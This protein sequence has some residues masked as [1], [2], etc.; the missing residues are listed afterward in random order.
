L[1]INIAALSIFLQQN[2]N[3]M[4][5]S[6]DLSIKTD[7][8]GFN[9]E[10]FEIVSRKLLSKPNFPQVT[11]KHGFLIFNAYAIKALDEC[12]H[13]KI[14][15]NI[16]KK[17]MIAKPC[18]EYTRDSVQWSKVDKLGNMVPKKIIGKPFTGRLFYDMY[19]DFKGTYKI[20]GKQI[21]D[22]DEKMLEFS[23]I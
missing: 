11:L 23:L 2:V 5:K 8:S 7:R 22:R 3:I 13:I 17:S 20:K 6:N 1:I 18:D 9:F 10:G 21:K 19:W 15:I 4:I 16:E 12:S 14:L